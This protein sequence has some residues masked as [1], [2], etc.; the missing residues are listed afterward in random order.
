MWEKKK[1]ENIIYCL[2]YCFIASG[3]SW[4]NLNEL[5]DTVIFIH[6]SRQIRQFCPSSICNMYIFW[7]WLR[8]SIGPI[9][10]TIFIHLQLWPNAMK[11]YIYTCSAYLRV[12]KICVVWKKKKKKKKLMMNRN[13]FI[14]PNTLSFYPWTNF[15]Y[16]YF[17]PFSNQMRTVFSQYFGNFAWLLKKTLFFFLC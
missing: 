10:N 1:T 12:A 6:A 11:F 2:C 3:N 15:I 9:I 13:G 5:C 17:T 7:R 8:D 14:V 4:I 16:Y